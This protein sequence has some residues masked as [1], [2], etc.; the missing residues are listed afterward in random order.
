MVIDEPL[1]PGDTVV[2]PLSPPAPVVTV[3]EFDPSLVV[4]TRHGFQ[5]TM[6]VPFELVPT[7]T[8][9]ARAGTAKPASA[10]TIEKIP[11]R[12]RI[13]QILRRSE[14]IPGKR[15][16]RRVCALLCGSRAVRRVRH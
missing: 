14:G 2:L 6:T 4:T 5:L 3:V 12:M 16:K 13:T 7:A 11:L 9:S 15:A 1:P 10:S 8:L